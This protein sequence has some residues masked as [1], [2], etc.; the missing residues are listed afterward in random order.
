MRKD[1]VA[2]LILLLAVA[3]GAYVISQSR[4]VDINNVR[5]YSD[6]ITEDILTALE[7][8]NY[9]KFSLYMD[10]PMKIAMPEEA[11][12]QTAALIKSKVGSYISKELSKVERQGSYIVVYYKAKYTEEAEVTVKVV[13]VESG[14]EHYV[15]GLWF[16]SP[17]LRT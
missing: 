1:A 4:T 7:E 9:T 15:S 10:P 6:R 17:K 14:G 2:V 16:D 13:F 3:V 8:G 11:F 5:A 12:Q